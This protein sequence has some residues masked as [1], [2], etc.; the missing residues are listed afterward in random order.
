MIQTGLLRWAL[1]TVSLAGFAHAQSATLLEHVR[2]HRPNLVADAQ[3]ELEACVAAK[4]ANADRLALLTGFLELSSGDAAAAADRLSKSKPPKGLEAF[5]AWYLGEAQSWSGNRAEALKSITQARKTAPKWLITRIDRRIAELSLELGQ[6]ARAKT[7]LDADPDVTR[8]PELLFS[9]ALLRDAMKQQAKA[10]DDWKA[11]A[12]RFPNHPHGIAA[13]EK[14]ERDGAWKLSFEEAVMRAEYLLGAGDAKGCLAALDDVVPPNEKSKAKVP[15]KKAKLALLRGQAL[16]SRGKERDAEAQAQLAIAADGPPGIAAPALMVSARRFMRLND[17]L[18][19]RT[20]FHKVDETYPDDPSADEAAYLA[21]WLAMNAADF[22]A[23][24]AEFE[25]FET[26]H[27]RSKKKDEARWFRGF[28][29]FRAKEYEK[30]REVLLT[31]PVD[32]PKSSLVPQA[33]YWSARAAQLMPK[34]KVDFNAEYRQLVSSFPGTFYGLLSSERLSEGGVLTALPFSAEPRSLIVKRPPALDLAAAL[35]ETGLFRDAAAEVVRAVSSMPSSEALTWGHALQSLGD[36]NAA[37][38]IAARNLWGACY[39]QRAPEALA[40]MYPRAF[41]ASVETWAEQHG[42]EPSLAWAIMRRESAFAPEVTSLADARGLMQIIPPT[43]KSIT[44]T[45]NLPA[46]DDAE[47]YSPEWNIRLG[48]WYLKALQDRLKHPTLVAGAYNGGPN[49][50][51]RWA[52]ER[53]DEPLDLWVE[54]IPFKETRGYV[55]QVTADLFI[56]RQLYGAEPK[57]LSLV[58]PQPGQGVDF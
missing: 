19:A 15:A 2:I 46:A 29:H 6:Y 44:K 23:A 52:K 5:H 13:K 21:A 24:T 1:V 53:G 32:F 51:A 9:R 31:L 36:F 58:V 20:A 16:L 38:V 10:R 57:R 27:E 49:A 17:N 33:L 40:L 35:A 42:I 47:L 12:I 3:S 30:A 50:V 22:P 4:C 8:L 39:V 45:L 56:Y 48:T 43:A 7:L 41:R 18:A 28:S 37:H 54:Q 25:A 34:T 11:L 14:L 26:K 55:K